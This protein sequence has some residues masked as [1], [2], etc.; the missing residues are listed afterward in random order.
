MYLFRIFFHLLLNPFHLFHVPF[1][2]LFI[3]ILI[4]LNRKKEKKEGIGWKY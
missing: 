2:F 1:Q 3:F 4:L